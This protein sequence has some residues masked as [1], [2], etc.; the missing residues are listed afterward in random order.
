LAANP[1]VTVTVNA[2]EFD[3]TGAAA[4]NTLLTVTSDRALN[5]L[6]NAG[7][8]VTF[9]GTPAT[10]LAIG[11]TV[12]LV[13]AGVSTYGGPAVTGLLGD[14]TFSVAVDVPSGAL[15][16]TMTKGYDPQEIF[17]ITGIAPERLRQICV[18]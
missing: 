17:E 11:D 9:T 3:L 12:T 2:F 10:T 15:V 18:S 6:A 1:T 4:N 8:N 7:T 14:C 16:A 13:S 5:L